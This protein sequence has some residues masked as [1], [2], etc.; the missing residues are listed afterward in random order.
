MPAPS[1]NT[2]ACVKRLSILPCCHKLKTTK[3]V[4]DGIMTFRFIV[5]C[6]LALALLLRTPHYPL[7]QN[8]QSILQALPIPLLTRYSEMTDNLVDPSYAGAYAAVAVD[9]YL[10]LGFSASVPTHDNWGAVFARTS[11]ETLEFI[12]QVDEQDINRIKAIGDKVFIPGYDPTYSDEWDAG[13]L[14]IY[15]TQTETLDKLR[16]RHPQPRFISSTVTDEFGL[17]TFANLNFNAYL[18]RIVPPPGYRFTQ[19]FAVTGNTT[20]ERRGLDSNFSSIGRDMTC[21]DT[22]YEPLFVVDAAT[23]DNTLDA[24]LVPINPGESVPAIPQLNSFVDSAT[25]DFNGP[26]RLGNRVWEDADGDGVQED[27]EV[28]IAD[29]EVSLYSR[30]PYFPCVIHASGIWGDPD[31]GR[32][33][34]NG[35]ILGN[36]NLTFLSEDFGLSWQ[37]VDIDTRHYWARDLIFF[38]GF[39][40][41]LHRSQRQNNTSFIATTTLLM[42]R[43]LQ[44]WDSIRLPSAV[45]TEVR[46]GARSI[47]VTPMVMDET[48]KLLIFRDQLIILH[49]DG[50]KLYRFTQG[51]TYNLLTISGANLGGI[52]PLFREP[53]FPARLSNQQT[54]ASNRYQTVANA[55]DELLYAISASNTLVATE[56]LVNWIEI[57][58]LGTRSQSEA[59]I[60]LTY[61]PEREQVVAITVGGEN[62]K[63]YTIEHQRVLEFFTE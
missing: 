3:Q 47:Q 45:T 24:G 62:S 21:T 56:D 51:N 34:Y 19:P 17:Y 52:L 46:T 37:L 6:V 10:Y 26:V 54:G 11:G 12:A 9:D 53:D 49:P 55:R 4:R 5:F 13:N 61:W 60:T 50:D 8:A 41:K 63:I 30:D 25:N 18:L 44:R 36:T 33:I 32:I 15:D 1:I 31:T 43:D 7:A 16:Y 20:A 42:S 22:L 59:F 35:G 58:N 2:G 48:N 14:Y 38:N 57:A 29:V 40:Y 28:G 23:M 27:G 39:Y